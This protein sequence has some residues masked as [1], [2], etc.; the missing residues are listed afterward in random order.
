MCVEC[1]IIQRCPVKLD[2][3]ATLATHICR[4]ALYAFCTRFSI[5]PV[6]LAS[7]GSRPCRR[8]TPSTNGID[9]LLSAR[10]TVRKRP[11]HRTPMHLSPAGASNPPYPNSPQYRHHA[12]SATA[13]QC[14]VATGSGIA[15]AAASSGA[16]I[17]IYL[18][19]R[20]PLLVGLKNAPISS[21]RRRHE[22]SAPSVAC[23]AAAP[24]LTTTPRP[25]AVHP[26]TVAPLF[27][28]PSGQAATPSFGAPQAGS[29]E[30]LGA[31]PDPESGAYNFAI[32]RWGPRPPRRV[33]MLLQL[34]PVQSEWH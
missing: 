30:P 11:L 7:E 4:T 15:A 6:F 24:N 17:T 21:P 18:I 12:A 22:A 5:C 32:Y 33:A 8:L 23:R 26:T 1:C 3:L 19:H 10:P 14:H 25:A 9:R 27:T 31:T 16:A 2:T 13:D 20:A 34:L 29:P 28:S